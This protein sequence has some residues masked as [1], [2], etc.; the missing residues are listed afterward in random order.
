MGQH[1]VLD[2]RGVVVYVH[3]FDGHAGDIAEHQPAE[4]IRNGRINTNQIKLQALFVV[5]ARSA[6]LILS[7]NHYF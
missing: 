5:P 1:L 6:P 3:L 2:N 7:R 4:G